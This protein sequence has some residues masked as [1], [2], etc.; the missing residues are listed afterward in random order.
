MFHEAFP[1]Y[2]IDL[3]YDLWLKI[4]S[5]EYKERGKK[6]KFYL[7]PLEGIT[8]YIYRRVYHQMFEP[9]DTYFIPFLTPDENGKLSKRQQKDVLPENNEGLH[10]I[11][12]ILTNK[13]EEFLSAVR[14]LT[15]LGYEEVNLNLGCPSRCVVSKGRGAGFLADPDRLQKFLDRIFTKTEIRISIKTRIGMHNPDEFRVLLDI[16]NAYPISELIIHP[17]TGMEFY[18]GNPHWEVYRYAEKASK[19]ELCYNGDLFSKENYDLWKERFPESKAVM[20]GRGVLGD[21]LL[22]SRIRQKVS[23]KYTWTDMQYRLFMEYQREIKEDKH[24][25]SRLK[26]FLTYR[27]FCYPEEKE[28]IQKIYRTKSLKEYAVLM[29]FQI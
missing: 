21:P 12:Q 4:R 5:E 14:Y 10:V 25:L 15:N 11:P 16:F 1:A 27:A 28:Q 6:M 19:N 18:R 20:M 17:R 2:E 22:L 13:E 23:M 8:D 7:A 26:E 9:M 24:V 3:L 29:H